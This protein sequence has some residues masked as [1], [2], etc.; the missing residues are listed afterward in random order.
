[1]IAYDS[2]RDYFYK[3]KGNNFFK[4]FYFISIEF[5]LYL[6]AGEKKGNKALAKLL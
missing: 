6:P 4:I 5:L 1:M 2:K 3:K